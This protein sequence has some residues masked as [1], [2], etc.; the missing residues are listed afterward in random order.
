MTAYQ[1]ITKHLLVVIH[2]SCGVRGDG[3]GGGL[4]KNPK[5]FPFIYPFQLSTLDT[6]ASQ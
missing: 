3:G 2:Q 1:N 6:L 4:Q 5:I